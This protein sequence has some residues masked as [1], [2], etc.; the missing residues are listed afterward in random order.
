MD[1]PA[2]FVGE[3]EE[4]EEDSVPYG[5]H[6]KEVNRDDVPEVVPEEGSPSRRGRFA[7]TD[8]VSLYG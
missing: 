2:A 8:H 7:V 6:D 5:G 3:D 4:H 1:D